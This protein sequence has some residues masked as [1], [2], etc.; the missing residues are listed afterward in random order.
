MMPECNSFKAGVTAADL[1]V[2]H[3]LHGGGATHA[4][5]VGVHTWLNQVMVDKKTGEAVRASSFRPGGAD[6]VAAMA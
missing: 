4:T 3:S 1:Y 2:V 6:G 5:G